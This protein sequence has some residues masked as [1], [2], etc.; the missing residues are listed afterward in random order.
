VCS[1]GF[2]FDNGTCLGDCSAGKVK[3]LLTLNTLDADNHLTFSEQAGCHDPDTDFPNCELIVPRIDIDYVADGFSYVCGK[4]KSGFST[5]VDYGSATERI[6]TH[7]YNTY[8][9]SFSQGVRNIEKTCVALQDS[10]LL[11]T[12]S[13]T[14]CDIF[15]K[16]NAS[17]YGCIKCENGKTGKIVPATG[18]AHF[19]IENCDQSINSCLASENNFAG[20][21]HPDL[22]LDDVIYNPYEMYLSCAVCQGTSTTIPFISFKFAANKMTLIN[23]LSKGDI[24]NDG[25]IT[26][27][28]TPAPPVEGEDPIPPKELDGSSVSCRDYTKNEDFNL[29]EDSTIIFTENCALGA[30]QVT[31][32]TVEDAIYC[33]A[34][35]KGFYPTKSGHKVVSCTAIS[36][37]QGSFTFNSCS[38]CEVPYD[39][40]IQ[41][42]T[43]AD[44]PDPNCIRSLNG[45]CKVCADQ[46]TLN[47]DGVCEKIGIYKCQEGKMQ[48]PGAF[49]TKDIEFLISQKDRLGVSSENFGCTK[50]ESN[51][52]SI[53]NLSI[54]NVCVSSSYLVLDSLP[55]N[56][57]YIKNCLKYGADPTTEGFLCRVCKSGL[58]PN[59]NYTECV[60][61]L[62]GCLQTQVGNDN[63]CMTC[64]LGRT[65]VGG[66]CKENNIA[67]CENYITDGATLSCGKCLEGYYSQDSVEC[68]KGKV[69]NCSIYEN[70]SDS[71]CL[72]CSS[73]FVKYTNVQ[74][75]TFC[76]SYEN[77]NCQQWNNASSFACDACDEGYFVTTPYD[78]DPADYC[79]G[80]NYTIPNCNF[81]DINL[82]CDSCSSQ[83]YL[84]SSRTECLPRKNTVQ[85]CEMYSPIADEC[86]S[87]IAKYYTHLNGQCY[88]YPV[89][90]QF[91]KEYSDATTCAK[92]DPNKFLQN[93]LCHNVVSF[94]D[95]CKYYSA[96]GVCSECADGK[97]FVSET[98]CVSI[99]A[100]NCLEVKSADECLSCPQGY[101]FVESGG[102]KSC[103]EVQLANCSENTVDEPYTCTKCQVGFYLY[104]NQCFLAS[105][106]IDGCL[107]YKN[108]IQCSKCK[109]FFVLSKDLTKC[110]SNYV[111]SPQ[112]DFNCKVYEEK[113][114]TCA[115]C[116]PNQFFSLSSSEQTDDTTDDTTT[117]ETPARLLSRISKYEPF[118]RMLETSTN[119]VF[120]YACVDCGGEGCFLC[121]SK[122][123][124][125]CIFC[126]PGFYMDMTGACVEVSPPDEDEPDDNVAIL[127]TMMVFIG[128]FVFLKL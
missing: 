41:S 49:K 2:Y 24:T 47:F 103:T 109:E 95:N 44:V 42:C 121:D 124:S 122:D 72:A 113:E 25:D 51:F 127:N 118:A 14:G 5:V 97:F 77:F 45:V 55:S 15:A 37:C 106:E 28:P 99:N 82:L 104:E 114:F 70:N 56:T 123:S 36:K 85:N 18:T 9:S 107:E 11:G 105:P 93:N 64:D 100:V 31:E 115:T 13:K 39:E 92:C 81:I 80:G 59:G 38:K 83:Y 34:C 12:E 52:I 98:S 84:N 4:C 22:L 16:L 7:N 27:E 61:Q 57:A 120:D 6:P 76:L 90:I 17:K 43:V 19:V 48:F 63:L 108:N 112:I 35:K 62:P 128:L 79:I 30:Y 33:L 21:T 20:I 78:T 29:T 1:E 8:D 26:V 116:P 69:S 68:L 110:L 102:V 50:C 126:K 101:G 74:G 73:R 65:N 58:I 71:T 96:D 53:S 23:Y 119:S 86:Q 66:V 67:N 88:P 111:V 94:V 87:C 125:L 54:S 46:Y 91:C 32:S 75:K 40:G 10:D 89:G 3:K 117:D 60:N